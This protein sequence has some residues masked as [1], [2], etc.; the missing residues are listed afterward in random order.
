MENRVF[1]KC[2]ICQETFDTDT[3]LQNIKD[4]YFCRNCFKESFFVRSRPA[5]QGDLGTQKKTESEFIPN[6]DQYV[7]SNKH[8]LPS[9]D[10]FSTS[11]VTSMSRLPLQCPCCYNHVSMSTLEHHFKR[12]HS[13]KVPIV[14]IDLDMCCASEFDPELIQYKAPQC[15]FL[16]KL[17]NVGRS[18][19]SLNEKPMVLIIA[20]RLSCKDIDSDSEDSE[21]DDDD[22]S[23]N[24]D[25][26]SR[27][28][29]QIIIWAACNIQ[30]TL[31]CTVAV[32][33]INK[34]IRNKFFGK[35]LCLQ[36]TPQTVC[37]EGYGLMLSHLQCQGMTEN[38]RK[39]LVL[40]VVVHSP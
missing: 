16:L 20:A 32:S 28:G 37:K 40:E 29:D 23:L 21:C 22:S 15:F 24:S 27:Q 36:E 35:M 13:S 19:D 10:G 5:A 8:H 11:S 34:E 3:L 30:T 4:N 14:S 38:G 6:P 12:D 7:T 17:Q 2:K 33:M 26:V 39:P 25:K 18:Y 1:A 31:S 9:L